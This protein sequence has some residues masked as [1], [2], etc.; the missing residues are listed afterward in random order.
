MADGAGGQSDLQRLLANI[1]TNFATMGERTT[2]LE[3]R[4]SR[5][6]T[7]DQVEAQINNN[8]AEKIGNLR[9]EIKTDNEAALKRIEQSIEA[10]KQEIRDARE[11]RFIQFA[12]SDENGN[13]VNFR[14]AF[15]RNCEDRHARSL[16]T[17]KERRELMLSRLTLAIKWMA[18]GAVTAGFIAQLFGVD[19]SFLLDFGKG[20]NR[21]G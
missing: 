16:K 2:R 21:L 19:L 6:P 11:Q 4:Q 14:Q 9:G 3:E 10:L 7:P 18:F 15:E 1:S 20:A 8:I 5:M 17:K 12:G 13:A